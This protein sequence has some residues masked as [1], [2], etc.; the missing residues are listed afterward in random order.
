[1]DKPFLVAVQDAIRAVAPSKISVIGYKCNDGIHMLT[2]QGDNFTM[3]ELEDIV[4]AQWN[5]MDAYP[6]EFVF[7]NI[8]DN[9]G[10]GENRAISAGLSIGKP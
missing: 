3:T 10:R 7:V 6:G 1:M 5:T 2:V 4:D 9:F 8:V